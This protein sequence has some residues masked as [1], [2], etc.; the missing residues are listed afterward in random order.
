MAILKRIEFSKFVSQ[1]NCFIILQ[2]MYN[3]VVTPNDYSIIARRI[4]NGIVGV[5]ADNLLVLAFGCVRSDGSLLDPLSG[6]QY[7][8][9]NF[10]GVRGSVL[11]ETSDLP[12][13]L[14]RIFE[15]DGTEAL[16]C[17]N[18]L[19]CAAEYLSERMEFSSICIAMEMH[20]GSAY[21]YVVE[22]EDEVAHSWSVQMRAKQVPFRFLNQRDSQGEMESETNGLYR[23]IT[24]APFQ[25][26]KT[27]V[28]AIATLAIF[29]GEPY[30][31]A[32]TNSVAD[33][34]ALLVN[35]SV[36]FHRWCMSKLDE[37][38]LS[39]PMG[40]NFVVARQSHPGR[41]HM[42]V[43]ERIK[44]RQ[45]HASGS[46]AVALAE[47][48]YH[49]QLLVDGDSA[50]I[51][52]ADGEVLEGVNIGSISVR[53]LNGGVWKQSGSTLKILDGRMELEL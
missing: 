5:G 22:A 20:S 19:K 45:T 21:L 33:D 13:A 28:C 38:G 14:M 37:L 48:A 32:C 16:V 27:Q 24:L 31:V 36:L 10:D 41:F 25:D 4:L 49:L 9:T 2:H 17:G 46:G 6:A 7:K 40:M 15:P 18:G 53:R 35:D 50:T 11:Q 30:L 12:C 39:V 26:G 34:I 29:T 52:P 8:I 51:I 47:A 1:G 43:F 42:R 44:N 23:R 3:S